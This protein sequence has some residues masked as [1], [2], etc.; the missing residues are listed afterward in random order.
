MRAFVH[1]TSDGFLNL[2]RVQAAGVG[3]VIDRLLP[4]PPVFSLIQKHGQIADEEMFV[5]YNMGVGFCII[6]DP[7][8]VDQVIS[9]VRRHGKEASVIGHVVRDDERAVYVKEKNLKGIG[10]EFVKV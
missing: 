5:V 2:P 7:S 1:I 6:V 8:G 9:T 3:F 4:V 10:K